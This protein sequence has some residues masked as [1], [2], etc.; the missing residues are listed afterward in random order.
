VTNAMLANPSLAI[1]A[2]SGL[3]GG[4][5]VALGGATSLNLDTAFTDARYLQ[6]GG[7][8]LTGGLTWGATGTATSGGGFNSNPAD[9]TASAFNSG[10]AAENQTFRW[11]TEP[12]SNNTASPSGSLNLLFSG[13]GNAFTP[14]ETGLS[15][16]SDGLI[17]F[18]P[19]QTFPGGGGGSVTQVNTGAGL[20]GGPI[21]TTG[22]ISIADAGVTNGML[23]NPSLAVNAGPG[24]AG[25]GTVALGGATTV[26]LDTTFTDS[27]YLSL[28][29]GT[30]TGSLNGTSATFTSFVQAQSI[31]A[32]GNVLMGGALNVSIPN[33][34]TTGTILNQLVEVTGPGAMHA[35]N[36]GT[37][38]SVGTIG[39]VTAG[40]GTS[41][42]AQVAIIGAANCVFDGPS[43][44][45]DYI[46]KSTTTAGDCHD[47]GATYPT[48]VQLLGRAILTNASAT[49]SP[50]ALYPAEERS[51]SG[52]V[53]AV[54][55]SAPLAS[56]S[57]ATPNI[58]LTGVIAGG[59]LPLTTSSA[60]VTAGHL[61]QADDTRL[62][63]A[64]VASAVNFGTAALAG[65]VPS[66]NGGTGLNTSS[67]TDFLR[68]D[69]AGGWTTS[70]IAAADV[71]AI[72]GTVYD[73]S[74]NKLSSAHT[75]IGST[76]L[77]GSGNGSVTLASSAVFTNGTSYVC[78]VQDTTNSANLLTISYV[79][80]TN[81]TLSSSIAGADSIRF[82]CTGN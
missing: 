46:V 27:R 71:P 62:S 34:G 22:S 81:F 65:T 3:A 41:G 1:T 51:T 30:L 68:G 21:T 54:S 4:G 77:D 44:A 75:V 56:S 16:A 24:L 14:T 19:G 26:N 55:A 64:R 33:D 53:T 23:A 9:L 36:A 61:V 18:A 7:G 25:G 76:T 32:Q 28:G 66:A 72:S 5:T 40:A 58:S 78:F 67:G 45:G 60:D 38:F 82:S 6:L 59:N 31:E 20:T 13:T 70:A 12:V 42:F 57:G 49:T 52:A 29:G 79:D 15:I 43:T 73:T 35:I 10:T 39:I 17:T 80:G 37:D 48:G 2:G 47:F 63:D 8:T 69:G 50:I 11:Q 74:G